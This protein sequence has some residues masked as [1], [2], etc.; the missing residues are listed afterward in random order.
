MWNFISSNP[1][2]SGVITTVILAILGGVLK[3]IIKLVS[4]FKNIMK[5][6]EE[7]H[8]FIKKVL[9]DL[10]KKLDE[11]YNASVENDKLILKGKIQDIHERASTRGK[12]GPK[13]KELANEFYDRYHSMGGNGYI[14]VLIDEIN[15]MN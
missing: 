9:K 10:D 15:T 6:H 2:L 4:S 7:D 14:K 1:I 3:G 8:S 11:S 13:D 5:R 12:L